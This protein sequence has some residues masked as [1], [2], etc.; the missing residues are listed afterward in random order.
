MTEHILSIILFAPFV[1]VVILLFIPNEKPLLVR[2]V[3]AIAGLI[4]TLASFYLLYHYDST[5]G[6]Y[7]F[8]EQYVW[9]KDLGISFFLGVDGISIPLVLASSILLFTG[10]FISWHIKDR[11]KEFYAFL[12]ILAAAT[13]GVYVS[14]DLFFL[15]FFYEMSVLPMYVLLGIWGSHTKGYLEMSD[16]QKRDSVGFIFNFGSNSKEYAAMKLTLFLSAGAVV[17]LVAILIIY[18]T[19]GLNTFNLVELQAHGHIPQSLH[20]LLFLLIFFGFAT[21]APLWPLH[22]WSPVGHAA[23]PAA[24]SML[25]AGVLMKLGHFSIIRVGYTLFPEATREWMPLAAVLCVF[26]IVYGGLVAYFQ[27]DTKYVIGY[28]S[29]SHMGYV[30]LG[31][32]ALNVIS[33]TGA[34]LYMFAHALATGMLFAIAGFVYDQTH[35]RDIPSLGGLSSR[36]PFIA[37]I[38][39]VAVAAS[40]GLPLTV[41]FIGELMI[42]VGSWSLYP[43]QTIIAVLGIGLTLAYLFRMM[44]GVFYGPMDPHY[45]HVH[46]ASPVVDRLPLLVMAATSIYFGLFPSQFIRVIRAGVVPLIAAIQGDASHTQI[47]G[48]F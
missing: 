14:L 10:V 12:L 8:T 6:G 9:S 45:A 36:M 19:S 7:Q 35:T 31:M 11:A 30:F 22:S 27:R 28:S 21:I 46:D 38:F 34:V 40:F 47:G 42:L 13:I 3:A 48:L 20:G 17:A 26:S 25:H 29:S 39:I 1:G 37:G 4:P 41:N 24:V 43:V 32:A 33:M 5:A 16:R 18:A 23:A 2:T 15:Y 44:R